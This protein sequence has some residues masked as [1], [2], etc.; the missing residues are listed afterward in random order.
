MIKLYPIMDESVIFTGWYSNGSRENHPDTKMIHTTYKK[1]KYTQSSVCIFVCNCCS[2]LFIQ[3]VNGGGRP[4]GGLQGRTSEEPSVT[5][6]GSSTSLGHRGASEGWGQ[7]MEVEGGGQTERQRCE[8]WYM[9]RIPVKQGSGRD[10]KILSL[11]QS[12]PLPLF[13]SVL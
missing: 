10:N 8:K 2:P 1:E 6:T 13:F 7:G 9:T 11:R 12:V 3:N 5:T 4:G